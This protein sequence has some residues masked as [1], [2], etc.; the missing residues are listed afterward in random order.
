MTPKQKEKHEARKRKFQELCNKIKT[1]D[2]GER[3]RL[4]SSIQAVSIEG[5]AYSP[6]NQCMLAF[7]AP[8]CTVLGG[9]RQ[10]KK[11]GRSVMK[12]EH[13]HMIWIPCIRKA[14]T[15][16]A[17]TEDKPETTAPESVNFIMGTVF[18]VTQTEEIAA[19]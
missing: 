18:D 1:M 16:E 6:H 13:G 12:G 4:A 2:D 9:F 11:H 14:T 10:W 17:T 3:I 15:D 7:Q 19:A 5:A 8:D